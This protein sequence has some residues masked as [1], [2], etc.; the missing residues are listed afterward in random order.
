MNRSRS[1]TTLTTRRNFCQRVRGTSHHRAWRRAP[2]TCAQIRDGTIRH[3]IK[4]MDGNRTTVAT[5]SGFECKQLRARIQSAWLRLTGCQK[6]RWVV[7]RWKCCRGS[8]PASGDLTPKEVGTGLGRSADAESSV[9]AWRVWVG[10]GRGFGSAE[11]GSLC[12]HSHPSDRD[13]SEINRP[14]RGATPVTWLRGTAPRSD[15]ILAACACSNMASGTT[16]L[17]GSRGRGTCVRFDPSRHGDQERQGGDRQWT[18]VGTHAIH[19]GV[20]R[21]DLG[22][23]YSHPRRSADPVKRI[24][25]NCKKQASPGIGPVLLSRSP[26]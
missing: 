1:S 23:L 6:R 25:G 20:P 3:V 19:G 8:G 15:E 5:R 22:F 12:R 9:R 13:S 16:R 7:A 24:C 17:A 18:E 2:A 4:D 14:A 21:N 26:G 10:A 11:T